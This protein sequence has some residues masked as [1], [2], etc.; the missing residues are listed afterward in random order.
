M[1]F[2]I[3]RIENVEYSLSDVKKY[4]EEVRELNTEADRLAEKYSL[5]KKIKEINK[6]LET[7]KRRIKSDKIVEK[8]DYSKLK[9]MK[10]QYEDLADYLSKSRE[11]NK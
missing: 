4:V 9:Q 5:E 11:L 7:I 3:N 1:D 10:S 8:S 2:I 6:S